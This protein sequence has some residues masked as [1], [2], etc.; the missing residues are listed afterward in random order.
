MFT[1]A[2]GD[3]AELR[4]LEPWQAPELAARTDLDPVETYRRRYA[5]QLASGTGRLYGIWR[6]GVLVGA[7]VF[8]CFDTLT[9]VCEISCRPEQAAQDHDLETRAGRALIDWAFAERGMSRVEWWVTA[10]DVRSIVA[11]RRL[12]MTRDGVLRERGSARGVRQDSEVWAVL[13]HEWPPVQGQN[14]PRARVQVELDRLMGLF[15]ASFTNTDGR[16]PDLEVIR[17]LFV[18]EGRII[19]NVGGEP[20]VMDLDAFI[21]PRQKMLTDGTL[22]EFSE[23]EISERT[24][25]FGSV[26]HR[27]SV[28]GKSGFRHGERFEGRGHKTTQY[29]RTPAGWRMCSMAWDD[30]P[31]PTSG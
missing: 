6:E 18:P 26:A 1:L 3:D 15:M 2:L 27:F 28:Y 24:E 22:T 14:E 17:H 5:D 19:S 30:E 7:A 29:L 23:W 4:P 20:S 16:Q 13:S 31:A 25:M 8:A 9:G 12:G 10:D 11:A 21:E